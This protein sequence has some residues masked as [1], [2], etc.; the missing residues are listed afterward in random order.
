MKQIYITKI[1]ILISLCLGSKMTFAQTFEQVLPPPPAPQ[2]I[3]NFEGVQNSSIAFADVDGDGD[4][5]VLV[6]GGS[7][8]MD[9][10]MDGGSSAILYLNDG[11]GNYTED[12]GTPFM[13][14]QNGSVAFADIDEDGDQ[15]VLITGQDN[16][17]NSIAILYINDGFGNF[18]ELLGTPFEGV[19]N[20]SI[21]F[22]DVDG[23][24]YQDV[25]I[26]GSSGD[27]YSG[28]VASSNL[29]LNDGNGNYMKDNSNFFEGV[30][31]GSVAF[32]DV[33]RDGHQDL[34]ITGQDNNNNPIAKLYKNSG[35]GNFTELLG[36]P[37][38]GV[39]NSSIA[40]ADVNGNGSQ[41]VLITGRGDNYNI[42]AKL[43]INDGAGKYSEDTGVSFEGVQEGSV[44]FADVDG[45]NDQD[46]LITGYYDFSKLYKNDG[47][48][49]FSEGINASFAGVSAGSI[50]FAD[51]D[52]DNDQDV[53][54]TGGEN[55]FNPVAKLYVN[56]GAGNYLEPTGTF[57][58]GAQNG[59]GAFADID[60]DDDQ[61][62]LITG[63]DKNYNNFAKL[64]ENDG[65]GNYSEV[66]GTPFEGVRNG[67]I[68]F[69]DIDDDGDQ[70]VMIT[71]YN[72]SYIAKLY[73]NDGLGNYSEVTDTPFEGVQNSSIAFADV[74]GDNDQDVLIAGY[75]NSDRTTIA[76][77][78]KNDGAGNYLES[79]G[80]SFAG[81]QR[82]SIA[83]ADMDADGDQ[84]VLITGYSNSEG[85]PI[86]KLYKNDGFGSYMEATETSFAEV[87]N[88]SVA[89]ADVDGDGDQDLLITG[90]S[91]ISYRPIAKL[92]KNDGVGNYAEVVGMPFAEVRYSSIAFTD[93]DGDGDQDVLI[94]GDSNTGVISKLY[95][96]DGSG[97]FS[98]VF[99]MPFRGVQNGSIA[100]AEIDGDGDQ[101][102]LITGT[103]EDGPSSILYRN[104][105][106][107]ATPPVVDQS[108]PVVQTFS[109]VH[110]AAGVALKPNLSITFDEAVELNS[111]GTLA[112]EDA[113][114][115]V[116]QTYDLSVQEDRGKFLFSEDKLTLSLKIDENLPGNTT[117]SVGISS[118][119][120]KDESGNGNEALDAGSNAWTFTTTK[121]DQTI[122]FTEISAKT[123]G[124]ST[125]TLG[126]EKTDQ[127]L[128]VTYTA[129]DPDVV[130]I[131]GNTATILKA[132]TTK[133]TATQT[134]DATHFA[135]TPV[136]Q[137]LSIDKAAITVTA[138]A[139]S[140]V[141][142]E[143][144]PE[145][146]YEVT[147][148]AL[149]GSDVFTGSL[150]RTEGED[151]GTYKIGQGSLALSKNYELKYTSADLTI[152]EAAI[153]VT[154]DAKSKVY[155]EEDP[156][157][158]YEVT[159]GAL[160]GSDAFTGSLSRTEGED[161]GTYEIGQGSLALSK[162]YEL[163]Y[164]PAD[165]SI[166]EAAIIVT[167]D[168][169]SKVYG[170]EDPELTYE[171]TSGALV[172][173]DVFTGSLSRTEGKDVGTYNIGQ[174]SLALSKNYEL[175]YTPADLTITEA[176]ITVTADAKSK[177]YGDTEPELTYQIVS[178][179]LVGSDAF[180][181]S[182]SR[183]E[184]EDVGT[185]KIGQGS[186]ALSKNYELR[187]TPADLTITEAAITVTADAKSKVYGETD[188]KLTYKV[189]SGALVG[190]DSLTGS[191]SRETGE[192]AGSYAIELGTLTLS[193]N[194]DLTFESA[195]VIINKAEAII[196]VDAVQ[197]FT[198]DGTV[199]NVVASLNHSETALTYAPQQ[200][201]TAAGTYKV[202]IAAE[203]TENYL[204]A[205]KAVSLEI[206]NA[207]ITGVTF[208]G[209]SFTY[210]GE[211]HSLTVTGLPEGAKVT[212]DNNGQ[213]TAGSYPV[214]ATISQDNFNDKVLT[215]ELVINKAEAIITADAVQTFTYDGTVKNVVASLNHSETALTYAP[216]QGYAAAGTYNVTIAAEGT[217][218]YLPA[219]K[220]VSLEIE[221]ADI[222]GVT[223]KGN[224]F[225]YDGEAHSL[226]V[227]GLPEGAKVTYD[228]NGQITA[229]SYP[230]T[231]TISQDNFNDKVLTAE[232]VINKAEAIITADAVQTFTYD[233][234][235]K[236]VVASLNHSETLLTYTPQ[237][238]YTNAG[239]YTVTIAA[240]GTEN[241]LPVS[242]DV[243]LEIENADITGVTFE[244]NSFTYDGEAH[245]LTVTGLPEGA[246]V[247]YDKNGQITAGSYSV[248]A[249][250]SQD[251]FNDK[252]LTA[253]LVI[254]KAE[255]IITA[256]AVQTFTYDGT[257]KNVVASL[258]HSETLLTYTPR[259]GYT[260]AGSYTV[261]IAAKGTKNYL[262]VSKDV[263][264]EI[265][266]ADI[267]GVTFEGNSFTYDGEAHSLTVTG[268]PEG[269][270]VTYDNNGQI[271]AGSYPVTATI[272][273]DNFNDKVLTAELV[274]NK[275]E[276]IITA[277]AVQTFTY[278][279]TIKNVV[280]SLNHSETE[281]T[282][283]PQQ[284]YTEAESYTVTIAAEETENYLPASKDV[285]L[286]I[287][288]ADITGVAFE[289]DTHTFTYDGNEQSIFVTG[290]PE[291]ATVS[292]DNNGKTNAGK[293]TVTATISQD[294]FNDK[295]LT[296][297]LVI[298]KAEAIITADAVQTFT[299]DGTVKNVV[300][301]LNHSETALTYTPQQGYTNA[302]SYT[303]TIAAKE[304]ENYLPVSKDVSLEIENADI[305][306]VTF[307]GNS[308]TYDGE[309]H[310][311]AVT[312]LPEGA[313]VTYDH[314]GQITA[315]SY[316]V[317]ATIS[318]DNFNDKVLTAE[319]VINKAE[320]MIT[321]DA[322]QTFTYDG[323]VK[324]VVASLNHSETELTYTP[325]QGY[326]EAESYTVTIAA[327]ETENYLP[328][329]KDVSLEI[330]KAD[331]TG[332]AFEEDTH[333]FTYDGNEHSIFVTGLPEGATVSYDNNGKTNAGKYTVTATISQDNFNDKVL[334]AEPCDQQGCAKHYF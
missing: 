69:A 319:L 84:D 209:N 290:L 327:E 165:L 196:T 102:V 328:A 255:A 179:A 150:N 301:S 145:L 89:F 236:N 65:S 317:T 106:I 130:S 82:G 108:G 298:N 320:A 274:I 6:T 15:D 259:Q 77:L 68:A 307:K 257:V 138:D 166:A 120:V 178:G 295:V 161:A 12:I 60:G 265:E 141:Y 129:Q 112:L 256:D 231:A 47:A 140:K 105:S 63:Q 7:G 262:P 239:S 269:A 197:T 276:A 194:Y 176:A 16:N 311:L 97:Y 110:Q 87:Q 159:S 304:T 172:G 287:E 305:L 78:Y 35:S 261:T 218:N 45:D 137:T 284:G 26:T 267:T 32:A 81:V 157:L 250:I 132:G 189:T 70:D 56:D 136:A 293:Y 156:E 192:D 126:N 181:G 245:S 9:S 263:S 207:D 227:T 151:V 114:G 76:K 109:P 22:A 213:I 282:Y 155:G 323:S 134:G 318:Q 131:S 219:S 217:E 316:P 17:Y 321:A 289:E 264:L 203:G 329:S 2:I 91:N 104:T 53:L 101:D 310:S 80:S 116:V 300:A 292:Y 27:P 128:V 325:Q 146:T 51:I 52:G 41:D 42:I 211:A 169:K 163:I 85:S 153:T 30:Q 182:L 324:N 296:A 223:F 277:D 162:N 253:E 118:G 270:K 4:Q 33:N 244:G 133:I 93:V 285:S 115:V 88:S 205:S 125:F 113:D 11:T 215:A 92:Y 147:S 199:K 66:I 170:D 149:V 49:N 313:K 214:T 111:S 164:T 326:T 208:K 14:V 220:A 331:I 278:D 50:A 98:E 297:E 332:V 79:T 252:V 20:S 36:T 44:A 232:L 234:T 272:S 254:N 46:L 280:A 184:G 322:V 177:V 54:I 167:A 330:E 242:K 95:V 268:L 72:N 188:P 230:V 306:G 185:Y 96:N 29:Y 212:Y 103:T 107:T 249:T 18:Q 226:T 183:T 180:T 142:G 5:D 222:T 308:F 299:Y 10:T 273:Q 173:S 43:Y 24:G 235:V 124:G 302:G 139:K 62:V 64:Y 314:N 198:Y 258:N 13:G 39:Q 279:G 25:L 59:S 99:G 191:L 210:D 23:D 271:T 57:F 187:Y 201:Y 73:K 251:N 160:V 71:G 67:S 193:N 48:G 238:G 122:T 121:L 333:T 152:T 8:G 281:L 206:E 312:G 123:Y 144:D 229:G 334:T 31:H 55:F 21:A 135:A 3:S 275:A 127:D 309:A 246:K 240:K 266:N 168:A 247:T 200:G 237:Q 119:F 34:L 291:G 58:T 1:L 225:T 94:S 100:F 204:P 143:T 74:D 40:F 90:Y 28:G 243:S 224:S 228:N 260:N 174:G 288:N 195:D 37:F 86:A 315:G 233:G 61:D 241:Y 190:S 202:T 117:L 19:Q 171:V 248:T 148:G 303:V 38:E 186:L 83:F 294:N 283:T 158:T 75:S 216:Q 154:V 175:K 286:E 221:N